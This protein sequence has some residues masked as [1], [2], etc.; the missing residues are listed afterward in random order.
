MNLSFEEIED[1]RLASLLHDTGKIGL[2]HFVFNKSIEELDGENLEE[3]KSHTLRGEMLVG[4]VK[5][6]QRAG[7]LIRHHHEHFDGT[8]FPDGLKGIGIPLGARIIALV[9]YVDNIIRG[10]NIFMENIMK[11]LTESREGWFDPQLLEFMSSPVKQ[12][13]GSFLID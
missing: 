5:V 9:N 10:G 8:G 12:L 7:I 3:Y 2:A 1:I 6:L 13:Y 4:Q 11:E